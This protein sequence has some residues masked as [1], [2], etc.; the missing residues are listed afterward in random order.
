MT[1]AELKF[2]LILIAV[3]LVKELI[4]ERNENT[5]QQYFFKMP[6]LLRWGFYIILVFSIIY[7][8]HY[9]NGNEHAC[10]YFQF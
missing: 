7:L 3:L 5:V 10:I 2:S 6:A 1:D 4:W 9:G 8:G